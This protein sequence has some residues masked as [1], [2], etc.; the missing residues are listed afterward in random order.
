MI[1][2]KHT[3]GALYDIET[4]KASQQGAG[5]GPIIGINTTRVGRGFFAQEGSTGHVEGMTVNGLSKAVECVSSARAHIA[6]SDFKLCGVAGEMDAG[7]NIFDGGGNTFNAGT[8]NANDIVW[9]MNQTGVQ[10]N[11]YAGSHLLFVTN[12]VFTPDNATVTGTTAETKIHTFSNLFNGYSW[13]RKGRLKVRLIGTITGNNGNKT[14]KLRAG[15][16]TPLVNNLTFAS[17]ARGDFDV[18]L[19][20]IWSGANTQILASKGITASSSGS[21]E[22]SAEASIGTATLDLATGTASDLELSV[23]FV[24]SSDSITVNYIELLKGQN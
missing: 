10:I 1:G 8:A 12:Q 19:E 9:L 18:E 5:Q 7:S 23:E 16:G 4:G 24:N 14:I 17:T 22:G 2:N 21:S 11:E 20:I 3:V 15:P 13:T 6:D